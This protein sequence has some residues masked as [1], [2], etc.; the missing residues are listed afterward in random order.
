MFVF[1]L[2]ISC[3]QWIR[4]FNTKIV[5]VKPHVV[6]PKSCV[7]HSKSYCNTAR[8]YCKMYNQNLIWRPCTCL[9]S[10]PQVLIYMTFLHGQAQCPMGRGKFLSK[11]GKPFTADMSRQ[12][13]WCATNQKNFCACPAT[14]R[15]CK[16]LTWNVNTLA[17]VPKSLAAPPLSVS[18]LWFLFLNLA[19]FGQFDTFISR[20]SIPL[21]MTEWIQFFWRLPKL[22]WQEVDVKCEYSGSID[23]QK[24]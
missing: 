7:K 13:L 24:V 9:L 18:D 16:K 23:V 11:T 6:C 1:S 5:F 3:F 8:N 12:L 4:N 2:F 17:P 15:T 10:A 20:W 14:R 22:Q 19:D 21:S